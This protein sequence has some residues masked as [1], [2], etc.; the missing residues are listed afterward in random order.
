MEDVGFGIYFVTDSQKVRLPVNPQELTVVYAGDNTTYNL[1]GTGE[2]VIP[3]LPKCVTVE[4]ES[5]FPRNSYTTL[6]YSNS[7][8]RPE[9][10]V[11]FFTMLQ[12]KRMT[13]QFIVNR[14]DG[15]KQMFD[16]SFKAVVQDFKITDR[17]GESGDVYFAI[18]VQEYRNTEPQ[19][20]EV[21]SVDSAS[22]TTELVQ[23]KQR[24]VAND[25][26]VV[27]D[28]VT[29]TGPVFEREDEVLS[30]FSKARRYLNLAN[31]TVARVLPPDAQYMLHKVYIM[32]VGWVDKAS[33]VKSNIQNSNNRLETETGTRLSLGG[34]DADA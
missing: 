18:S 3:R 13:F 20:V 26:I 27:G 16:T 22:D 1:S 4:L 24:D 5:Y 8:Y 17:G 12:R 30:T 23:T 6:T 25:E 10:Y 11:A 29:V 14:Y 31:H 9:F 34:S 28:L 33:C 32:N 21:K 19:R 15:D 2:V 7:W